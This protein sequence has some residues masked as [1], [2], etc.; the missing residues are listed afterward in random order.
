MVIVAGQPHKKGMSDDD[1]LEKNANVIIQ[2]MPHIAETCPKAL[3]AIVT[4]PTN[5]IVPLAA[6]V[7]K[8]VCKFSLTK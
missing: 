1:L 6:E 7:L 8:T 5:S 3:I 2:I 4:S